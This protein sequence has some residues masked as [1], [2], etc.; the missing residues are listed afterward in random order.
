MWRS[1]TGLLV[2]IAAGYL[3][4]MVAVYFYQPHLLFLPDL[5]SRE[6]TRTPSSVDLEY[7]DVY[8]TTRDDVRLHGWW[9]DHPRPSGVMLFLHGNAG[10]ISHRLQSLHLFNELGYRVLIIDYRGYGQSE[11]SPSEQGLY[12][13]AE[14]AW[15]YLIEQR[16]LSAGQI[17][18]VGRSLGAAVALDLAINHP[19]RAL[20]MES[21]FTSIADMAVIHYPWLP[22]RWLSRYHFNNRQKIKRL[23]CPLLIVHAKQDEIAP[24]SHG[25]HLYDL[26]PSPKQLL[27]LQGGHNDAQLGD[28]LTY[29]QGL[30]SFIKQH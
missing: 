10:N 21:A 2:T 28:R 24:Y 3:L 22:V 5:P 12:T 26:A 13:D 8:L 30:Q 1:M 9:V 4:F 23:N 29:R 19:P 17:V 18:V 20:I 14:A 16:G 15:R 7:T 25:Q 11:G 27:P 6:I